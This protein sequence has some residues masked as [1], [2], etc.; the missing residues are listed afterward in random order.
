MFRALEHICT[1]NLLSIY[2]QYTETELAVLVDD[3]RAHL[4][5]T[6]AQLEKWNAERRAGVHAQLV[7]A[8]AKEATSSAAK[9]LSEAAL[10]KRKQREEKRAAAARAKAL[11]EDSGSGLF[12]PTADAVLPSQPAT[13]PERPSTP[14]A[15]GNTGSTVYLPASVVY[16]VT[17]PASSPVSLPWYGTDSTNTYA[18]IEAARAAGVWTYPTTAFERAKCAVYRDLWKQGHFMGGGIRF[19]GDF[20]VYPGT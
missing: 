9:S 8:E 3:P 19:G 7:A 10:R 6:A 4:P 16:T 2:A 13:Q 12:D 11:A 1:N 5:P 15:T 18:T 20:L 17:V 14:K